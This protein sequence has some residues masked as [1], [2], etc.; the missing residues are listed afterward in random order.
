MKKKT[1]KFILP[2]I[3]VI[4]ATAAAYAASCPYCGHEYG[5]SAPG[6]EKRV[7]ELRRQHEAA[8]PK[9]PESK[10]YGYM[11]KFVAMGE[12]LRPM[13]YKNK[14]TLITYFN[15]WN[16]KY[17]VEKIKFNKARLGIYNKRSYSML[18][19]ANGSLQK[20]RSDLF[21]NEMEKQMSTFKGGKPYT[22]KDFEEFRKH[23]DEYF[24]N[25]EWL[26]IAVAE[27]N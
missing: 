8:C 18:R 24:K 2:A 3:I 15:D 5:K 9:G 23:L 16:E 7:H 1:I 10:Y 13:K 21:R 17:L 20:C 12:E 14:D 11:Q 19:N 22:G 27:K 4:F 6:D 25:L 26:K